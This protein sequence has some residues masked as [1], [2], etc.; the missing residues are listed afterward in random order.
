MSRL[1]G[2]RRQQLSELIIV[3]LGLRNQDAT[4]QM[5]DQIG[6]D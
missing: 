6:A 4:A 5:L 2:G 1:L 3:N